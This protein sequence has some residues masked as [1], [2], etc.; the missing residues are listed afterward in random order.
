LGF[1]VW[2]GDGNLIVTTAYQGQSNVWDASTGK[3]DP[4]LA[5]IVASFQ[6]PERSIS[7]NSVALSASGKLIAVGDSKGFI[8]IEQTEPN[9][10]II[11]LEPRE[12]G[13]SPVQM[14]FNP[15]NDTQLLALY[16]SPRAVLWNLKTG[17]GQELNH[18]EG[19]VLQGAFDP[20]GKFIVT[21][22]SDGTVPLW[23]LSDG[24]TMDPAIQL[25]G[26]HGPVFAVDVAPDGTIVSGSVDQSIRFWHPQPA[27]SL[28]DPRSY[29]L[30]EV[31]KLKAFVDDNLPYLDFDT[32]HITLPEDLFCTLGGTR[33]KK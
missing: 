11:R 24:A 5:D 23:R 26:H 15:A 17:K 19:N 33:A 12:G 13:F 31:T 7:V 30:G 4:A 21:A 2:S 8:T 9:E 16:Q 20:N 32:A 28:S 1:G 6:N 10:R 29:D 27:R 18:N 14:Y 25:R 3:P 22:A